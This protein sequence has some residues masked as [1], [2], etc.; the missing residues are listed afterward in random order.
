MGRIESIPK[1]QNRSGD[2]NFPM[3]ESKRK[4]RQPGT[5]PKGTNSLLKNMGAPPFL[6]L[7][8]V[9][10]AVKLKRDDLIGNPTWDF[11]LKQVGNK[12]IKSIY[13]PGNAFY[14]SFL[15]LLQWTNPD[16]V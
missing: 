6:C 4:K 10:T 12:V 7:G 16:K 1:W 15:P 5:S 3:V 14:I 2:T 9:S 11:L 13:Q 8:A